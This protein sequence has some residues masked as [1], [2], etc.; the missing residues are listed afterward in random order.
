MVTC[1]YKVCSRVRPW[2]WL[3]K[4][5][6]VMVNRPQRPH[7]GTLS[8]CIPSGE[9]AL[10]RALLIVYRALQV[11]MWNPAQVRSD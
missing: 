3:S 2:H 10:H 4:H 5:P 8:H 6:S 1:L 7:H 11:A 9:N